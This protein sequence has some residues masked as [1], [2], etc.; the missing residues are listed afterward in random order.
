MIKC[1]KQ[2]YKQYMVVLIT[3]E[4]VKTIAQKSKG[5]GGMKV[6]HW[7]VLILCMKKYDIT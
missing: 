1:L 6:H 3:Y 7:Q 5:K 2:K 4:K